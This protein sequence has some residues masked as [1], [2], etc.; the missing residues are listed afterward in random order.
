M[1]D[2]ILDV[3]SRIYRVPGRYRVR[4]FRSTARPVLLLTDLGAENPGASVTNAAAEI[5]AFACV[6]FGLVASNLT[7]IE[8]YDRRR[9]D[10]E[11]IG[12]N[13]DTEL[14]AEI[15]GGSTGLTQANA[16]CA[17]L[18]WKSRAKATVESWVGSALA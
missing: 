12:R 5:I 1:I 10:G 16:L 14:F 4:L 7:V 9:P 15:V 11:S 8:H 13:G 3:P 18:Q 17:A 6:R 2:E